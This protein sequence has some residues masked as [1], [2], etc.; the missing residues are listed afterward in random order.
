MFTP[1]NVWITVRKTLSFKVNSKRV[2]K[3]L[4][5][6]MEHEQKWTCEEK[7]TPLSFSVTATKYFEQN[8]GF[9]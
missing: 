9:W 8:F 6:F 4:F 3:N 5:C 2:S 7:V 1:D